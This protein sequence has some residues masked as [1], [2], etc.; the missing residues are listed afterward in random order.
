MKLTSQILS[1]TSLMPTFWP[2]NTVLR[3]I[4]CRLNRMRPQRVTVIVL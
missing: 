4:F 2:A 1:L 3:L